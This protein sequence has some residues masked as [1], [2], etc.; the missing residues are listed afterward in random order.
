M[1][2]WLVKQCCKAT[3]SLLGQPAKTK[4]YPVA[5]GNSSRQISST[6]PPFP[7]GSYSRVNVKPN[8]FK[9]KEWSEE[10]RRH[11]WNDVLEKP[12]GG[13]EGRAAD[14]W[15]LRDER[16]N[17]VVLPNDAYSGVYAMRRFLYHTVS[18]WFK[19]RTIIIQNDSQGNAVSEAWIKLSARLRRNDVYGTFKRNQRHEQK[20]A[21]R[22]RLES[23]RWRK[24]FA[25]EV[26]L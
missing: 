18:L 26:S 9:V 17:N 22:R 3:P 21:Q 13:A 8:K 14:I 23:Q 1:N 12:A 15:A 5:F 11:Q 16:A 19:G 20:G 2:S 7:A 24:S 10:Q 25:H 6:P 4:C